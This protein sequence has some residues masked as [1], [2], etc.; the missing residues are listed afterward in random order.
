MR[1]NVKFE[2]LLIDYLVSSL[3]GV[4]LFDKDKENFDDDFSELYKAQNFNL[5]YDDIISRINRLEQFDIIQ[6]TY[7][8]NAKRKWKI[9]LNIDFSLI[10]L[11]AIDI[12][13]EVVFDTIEK[14][15]T[16]ALSDLESII[17]HSFNYIVSE[18]VADSYDE[19]I[20]TKNKPYL[21]SDNNKYKP[22]TVEVK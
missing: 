5:T 17:L 4:I 20:A 11:L 3:D 12:V 1:Y 15:G 22:V 18:T 19:C 7:F 8:D 2:L 16:Y 10:Q 13:K 21:N 14:L 6:Q 9:E